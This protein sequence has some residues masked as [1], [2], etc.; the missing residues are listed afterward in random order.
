VGGW[1]AHRVNYVSSEGLTIFRFGKNWGK[2]LSK[3]TGLIL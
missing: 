2:N 3:N 1:E